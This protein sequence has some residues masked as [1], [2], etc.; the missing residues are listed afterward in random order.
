MTCTTAYISIEY[1]NQ[2]RIFG[3]AAGRVPGVQN[4]QFSKLILIVIL[5]LSTILTRGASIR[6]V[7]SNAVIF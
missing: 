7:T 2:G 6:I 3:K 1:S 5:K 4:K